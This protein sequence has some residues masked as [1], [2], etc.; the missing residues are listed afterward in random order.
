MN[1]YNN[2]NRRSGNQNRRQGNNQ[3]KQNI[4]LNDYKKEVK[5]YDSKYIDT[6]RQRVNR[7][8]PEKVM[9]ILNMTTKI[10]VKIS[11]KDLKA[12]NKTLDN[13]DQVELEKKINSNLNKL[14]DSNFESI[15]QKV[16]SI[17]ENRTMLL[18]FIIKNL[19]TKALTCNIFSETY[20]KFYKKFYTP[21]TKKIFEEMFEDLLKTLETT[22]GENY[23]DFCDYMK[24]KTKYVSLFIFLSN[25]FKVGIMNKET[26]EKYIVMLEKKLET[27]DE[28][29]VDVYCKFLGLLGKEFYTTDRKKLIKECSKNKEFKPRNRFGFM[30]LADLLNK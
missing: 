24:D 8:L 11:E 27:R 13:F 19:I 17:Y 20:A 9:L 30:D 1:N 28:I 25:L 22:N 4:R 6:I 15:Y 23:E 7:N 3:Y 10:K 18:K 14:T 12:F 29:N 21:E 26:I 2:Q 5:R 16:N